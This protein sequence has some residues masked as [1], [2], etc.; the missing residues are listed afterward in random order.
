MAREGSRCNLEC[1]GQNKSVFRAGKAIW[2]INQF[3]NRISE[4]QV[5][6]ALVQVARRWREEGG[7]REERNSRK[8]ESSTRPPRGDQVDGLPRVVNTESRKTTSKRYATWAPNFFVV[9]LK[10]RKVICI[11]FSNREQILN[12]QVRQTFWSGPRLRL[13]VLE[14][15]TGGF[16]YFHVKRG[17]GKKTSKKNE[18]HQTHL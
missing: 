5:I 16:N 12:L 4:M 18:V 17:I 9:I 6:H 11:S 3:R 2:K 8:G 10:I 13:C 1:L 15:F 7:S 14:Y